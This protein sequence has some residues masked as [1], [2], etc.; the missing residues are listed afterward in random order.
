MIF[1]Q[2]FMVED[3]RLE[4]MKEGEYLNHYKVRMMSEMGEKILK[5]YDFKKEDKVHTIELVV[6]TNEK[7]IKAIRSIEMLLCFHPSLASEVL[8]RLEQMN[9]PDIIPEDEKEYFGK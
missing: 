1:K 3:W 2:E 9:M 5:Y 6:V 7:Y 8:E 4:R